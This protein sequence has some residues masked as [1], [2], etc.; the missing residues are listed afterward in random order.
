MAPSPDA[1]DFKAKTLLELLDKYSVSDP[2]AI[3]SK[4]NRDT[5][6]AIRQMKIGKELDSSFN[7]IK[8]NPYEETSPGVFPNLGKS[9]IDPANESLDI[10][11]ITRAKLQ[12]FVPDKNEQM[13]TLAN[14]TGRPVTTTR[15][16]EI[17]GVTADKKLALLDPPWFTGM[18]GDKPRTR[19]KLLDSLSTTFAQSS[20]PFLSTGTSLA[21]SAIEGVGKGVD[22]LE[23]DPSSPLLS[24]VA[25]ALKFIS[26]SVNTLDEIG[27]EALSNLDL[28]LEALS[29]DVK[30]GAIVGGVEALARQAGKTAF[31][32][33]TTSP[34][35][36]E[37]AVD[38][39]GNVIGG[40]ATN[41]LPTLGKKGSGL[42]KAAKS[43]IT[44]ITPEIEEASKEMFKKAAM[45]FMTDEERAAYTNGT[46]ASLVE[47]AVDENDALAKLG[48][49][50]YGKQVIDFAKKWYNRPEAIARELDL[51]K[52]HW[53]FRK[54]GTN[55]VDDIRW[56][57]QNAPAEFA[58]V[59]EAGSLQNR[60]KKAAETIGELGGNIRAFYEKK[61]EEGVRA[62][63]K[64]LFETEAYTSIKE[65]IDKAIDPGV[66]KSLTK[67]RENY[68]LGILKN[69]E[70]D[71]PKLNRM[72]T[73]A[74]NEG[75]ISLNDVEALL[76][77]RDIPIN[78]MF[79]LKTE[80]YA[81]AN[82]SRGK[83]QLSVK[84]EVQKEKGLA[85]KEVLD[86][87][88]TKAAE[89][90]D[91]LAVEMLRQNKTFH[92]LI[93]IVESLNDTQAAEYKEGFKLQKYIAG[94]LNGPWRFTILTGQ[95][96]SRNPEVLGAMRSM[97]EG[98][99][100]TEG[101]RQ[102]GQN[103]YKQKLAGTKDAMVSLMNYLGSGASHAY[104]KGLDPTRRAAV[105]QETKD[106]MNTVTTDLDP[107][108]LP[109]DP[110]LLSASPDKLM[111]LSAQLPIELRQVFAAGMKSPNKAQKEAV[112][113]QVIE[114]AP[115]LFEPPINGIMSAV[116]R[117]DHFIIGNPIE[118]KMYLQSLPKL[119]RSGEIDLDFLATQ[120]SALNDQ[121][122]KK[123]L[124]FP[125]KEEAPSPNVEEEAPKGILAQ[126]L[127][128]LSGFLG[129]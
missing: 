24:K 49:N 125:K 60:Y 46:L 64:D 5:D 85:A 94:V 32:P 41:A 22:A 69:V 6:S 96:L 127:G 66:K 106:I 67:L 102:A 34:S 93:D 29:K 10:D 122:D 79:D 111:Q 77:T 17:A 42:L 43:K 105:I 44:G 37:A 61:A 108:P 2:A 118:E 88:I 129:K 18:S 100:S 52:K 123:I 27:T 126:S 112:L 71:Q 114:A 59:V 48:Y 91:P 99:F 82:W 78:R 73:A 75:T 55:T 103:W 51:P 13:A 120:V 36:G 14:V 57:Q 117:G 56:L 97:S 47:G 39:A 4:R 45:Q 50:R 7:S 9:I 101:A 28:P 68:L 80:N 81:L 12:L 109:R 84:Q 33:E 74:Y 26:P 89:E 35:L 115:E 83:K 95:K 72:V 128:T 121:N 70:S 25:S 16:G 107:T 92:Y 116:K 15:E 23:T 21:N 76:K 87:M 86:S 62:P 3:T 119:Y 19:S 98:S 110:E 54:D 104:N 65:S 31:F 63:L 90:G 11:P 124:P 53:L 113:L 20:S 58:P 8:E 1:L 38:V 30:T 40:Q